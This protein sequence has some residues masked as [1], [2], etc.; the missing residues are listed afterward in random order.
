MTIWQPDLS[1]YAGPRYQAIAEAIA[2]DFSAGRLKPGERLPPVRNLAWQLGVTVGTVNRGYMLA[3]SRGLV[4]SEV[5]RGTFVRIGGQDALPQIPLGDGSNVI[6]LEDAVLNLTRNVPAGD[7]VSGAMIA[8][9]RAIAADCERRSELLHQFL[10]YGDF[11]GA[12]R[13][14]AAGARWMHRAGLQVAPEQ[15][16]VTGGAQQGLCAVFGSLAE[17]GERILIERLT[18]AGLLDA[19][20]FCGL[21]PEGLAMDEE[22]VIPD[23]V[24]AACRAG[25]ARL[26][27]LV[28]TIQNPTAATMSAQRRRDIV[29]VARK[30]DLTI[31]EDDVYGFLP[32][33]RPLPIAALAP[34]RTVYLASDRKSGV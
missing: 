9:M 20:N 19:A 18:Y 5:G 32:P 1:R 2:A 8:T 30:H 10:S 3:E 17:P 24:D 34:E 11:A 16:V 26:L 22:G 25:P 4:S 23:A 33:E 12:M 21:K 28:P 29:A 6:D 14:R 31:I 13:Y 15:V 27:C 7:H